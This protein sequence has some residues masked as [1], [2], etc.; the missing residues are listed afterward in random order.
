LSCTIKHVAA[1][2]GRQAIV[3]VED[4]TRFRQIELVQRDFITNVLHKLR[5]PLSTLKTSLSMVQNEK[6]LADPVQT[7]EIL[8]MGYHEVNRL[9]DLVNDLRDLFQIET[10]LAGKDIEIE[11]FDVSAALGRAVDEIGKM[12]APFSGIRKRLLLTG[13]P[14]R[15]VGA[16]FAKTRKI[17]S[18]LLKN[19]VLYSEVET[20]IEV[21]FSDAGNGVMV[22]IKDQGTGIAE[23]NI[24]LLF[25]KYFR[26]DT[27]QTRSNEGNGLGLFIAKSYTDLMGGS[28]YCENVE[29]KGC[30]FFVSLPS[31]TRS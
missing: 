18:V 1:E 15:R 16:D 17:F 4:A 3:I 28:L 8:S 24:P 5:G 26:E 27:D 2:N 19:A 31:A 7:G 14:H 23:K 30:A 9:V 12:P 21:K 29:G 11:E 6:V 22:C 13:D 20:P 25:G 10:G